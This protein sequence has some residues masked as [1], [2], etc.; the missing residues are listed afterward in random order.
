MTD[1][2]V[3]VAADAPPAG[4]APPEPA[5]AVQ[6]LQTGPT[7][8]AQE[9]ADLN[10]ELVGVIKAHHDTMIADAK[11]EPPPKADEA[12][13]GEPDKP[14]DEAPEGDD[15]ADKE[16]QPTL[17]KARRRM[18]LAKKRQAEADQMLSQARAQGEQLQ[19]LI[20]QQA[21]IVQLWRTDPVAALER[22]LKAAGAD[23]DAAFAVMAEH[24][25]KH[26]TGAERKAKPPAADDA[27]PWAVAL[28]EEIAELKRSREEERTQSQQA[29]AQQ[30]LRDDTAACQ[31]QI[32]A[33]PSET[34]Y[35]AAEPPEDQNRVLGQ[36]LKAL[37]DGAAKLRQNPN[38]SEHLWV[39]H[40]TTPDRD[41]SEGPLYRSCSA[42]LTRRQRSA[43][44][45]DM[46]AF[47]S[48]CRPHQPTLR[49]EK[50]QPLPGNVP[51]SPRAQKPDSESLVAQ[52]SPPTPAHGARRRTRKRQQS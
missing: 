38:D 28:R 36:V 35:F 44:S 46:G 21:E 32:E 23:E 19:Q 4:G 12:P 37:H 2:A 42:S 40:F 14:A 47:S 18:A 22:S 33:A 5:P 25:L 49:A 15:E 26:G 10:A 7:D 9:A 13:G 27:P 11:G 1:V 48:S 17:T 24:R 20:A 6:S 39:K 45:T 3:T 31:R 41:S 30:W 8:E 50:V 51:P 43:T 34:P 16:P 29:A 52:K